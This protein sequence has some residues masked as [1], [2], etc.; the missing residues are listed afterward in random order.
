MSLAKDS[1][2]IQRLEENNTLAYKQKSI[3]KIAQD[4]PKYEM[5]YITTLEY[6]AT[7]LSTS[8]KNTH[9]RVKGGRTRLPKFKNFGKNFP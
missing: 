6:H 4:I 9:T 2:N 8:S 3:H 1:I 5:N 7:K